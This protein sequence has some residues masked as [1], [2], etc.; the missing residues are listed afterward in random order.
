MQDCKVNLWK[1]FPKL[2]AHDLRM[3][4]CFQELAMTRACHFEGIAWTIKERICLDKYEGYTAHRDNNG[5]KL[6][7]QKL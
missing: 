6:K 7:I 5:K 4:M 2:E 1:E 3:L